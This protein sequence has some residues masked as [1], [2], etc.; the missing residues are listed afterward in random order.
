MTTNT[1][2]IENNVIVDNYSSI[3]GGGIFVDLVLEDS[4]KPGLSQTQNT[5][6]IW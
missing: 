6:R 5:T 4:F 1:P 2:V 3:Y